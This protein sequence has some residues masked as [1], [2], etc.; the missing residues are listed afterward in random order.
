MC[1]GDCFESQHKNGILKSVQ[2]FR[3]KPLG[4]IGAICREKI[5]LGKKATRWIFPRRVTYNGVYF[6]VWEGILLGGNSA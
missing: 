1:L 5:I 4:I 6:S 3:T 2:T